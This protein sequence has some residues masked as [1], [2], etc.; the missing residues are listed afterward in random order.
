MGTTLALLTLLSLSGGSVPDVSQAAIPSKPVYGSVLGSPF[1]LTEAVMEADGKNSTYTERHGS[2]SVR[3]YK[4]SLREYRDGAPDPI[5]YI[6]FS[7]DWDKRIDGTTIAWKPFAMG[8]PEDNKQKGL[9]Q[10][11]V[12]LDR[13]ITRVSLYWQPESGYAKEEAAIRE[14]LSARIEFGKVK[15]GKLP[16]RIILALPDKAQSWIAG[17]FVADYRVRH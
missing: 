14:N 15:D 6:R 8:S 4:F 11:V 16:G 9:D 10:A 17:T 2:D 12:R 3:P 7:V 1:R 13:G 5:V